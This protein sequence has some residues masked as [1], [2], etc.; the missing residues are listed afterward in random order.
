LLLLLL[1]QSSAV[2]DANQMYRESLSREV[3]YRSA[4]LQAR[5]Y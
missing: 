5:M 3:S 4:Q 2:R 1:A